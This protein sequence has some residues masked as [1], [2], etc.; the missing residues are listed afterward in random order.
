MGKKR[1]T[2]WKAS[3]LCLFWSFW[4][5]RNRIA[6]EDGVLSIQR[7]KT[8]FVYLLWS[9]QWSFDINGFHWL[10][11]FLLRERLFF[12]Y[13]VGQFFVLALKGWASLSYTTWAV[14]LAPLRNT[15]LLLIKKKKWFFHVISCIY[16]A[17]GN[18]VHRIN[19]ILI[20]I[21]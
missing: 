20:V 10:G 6:F 16:Y 12:V 7:L 19:N 2:I 18:L 3:P 1:R 4:K 17:F 5:V 14:N 13:L 21:G 11:R 15:I 8:S 9:K